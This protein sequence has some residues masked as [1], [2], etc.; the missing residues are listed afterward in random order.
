M[1]KSRARKE[2]TATDVRNHRHEF[3]KAKEIEIQSWLDN[4][5]FDLVDTRR[6]KCKNY[7]TGRWVLTIKTDQAGVFFPEV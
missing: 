7:V 5:V 2:A 3:I 6:V 4:D 1:A